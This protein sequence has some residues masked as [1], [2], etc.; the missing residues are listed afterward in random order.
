MKEKFGQESSSQGLALKEIIANI[1]IM[2][3][4]I[5]PNYRLILNDAITADNLGVAIINLG[6]RESNYEGGEHIC[7]LTCN[8]LW[9]YPI[10]LFLFPLPFFWRNDLIKNR[11]CNTI[12]E[13]HLIVGIEIKT[14]ESL[15]DILDEIYNMLLSELGIIST[16]NLSKLDNS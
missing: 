11:Y 7:Y 1:R 8:H 5:I 12:I 14:N 16:G 6:F 13:G 4:K 9:E 10:V 15:K 2:N 3:S